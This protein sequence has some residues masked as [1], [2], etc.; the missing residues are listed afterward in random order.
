MSDIENIKRKIAAL[1]AKAESTDNAFEAETFMAK[2]NELLELHQI[3]MH[4]LHVDN[5]PMGETNGF[6]TRSHEWPSRVG[7][8]LARLYGAKMLRQKIGSRYA[9]MCYGRESAR[10]TF[11]M[12][13]P[14]VLSQVRQQA[15][16]MT[17]NY[18]IT[19]AKAE[20]EVGI[21]LENRIWQM[22]RDAD[23]RRTVAAGKGLIPVSDVDAYINDLHGKVKSVRGIS[24]N[25]SRQA[26]DA[27]AKVSLNVQATGVNRKMIAG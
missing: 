26:V 2:V 8:A 7:F 25:I 12:L 11:D 20:R 22:V 4:E 15:R 5:D 10:I 21:A 16:N 23:D 1:L 13:Y 3:E 18:A 17:R 27:A 9:W 19:L 6:V 24:A 14:F